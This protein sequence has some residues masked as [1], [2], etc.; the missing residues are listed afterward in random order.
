MSGA[1]ACAVIG[2]WVWGLYRAQRER[3]PVNRRRVSGLRAHL[4]A[5]NVEPSP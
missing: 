5:Q 1:V 2:A 4:V 3:D